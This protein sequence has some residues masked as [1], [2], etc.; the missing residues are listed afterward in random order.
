[1]DAG[2]SSPTLALVGRLTDMSSN[3]PGRADGV[4]AHALTG[5]PFLA[6]MRTGLEAQRE[7][8]TPRPASPA[9]SVTF[10][11]KV[12]P[13]LCCTHGAPRRCELIPRTPCSDGPAQAGAV[14]LHWRGAKRGHH[15]HH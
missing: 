13:C 12:R 4:Q 6:R 9:R 15:E 1:M 7:E 8:G 10:P 3:R 5:A 11:L 14:L 2:N